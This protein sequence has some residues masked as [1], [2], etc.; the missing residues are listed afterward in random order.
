MSAPKH[1]DL[2]PFLSSVATPTRSLQSALPAIATTPAPSPWSPKTSSATAP[3][4]PAIDVEAI[5][6]E[7]IESGRAEGL[8]ETAALRDRL[9]MLLREL[10]AARAAIA[11][12]TTQMPTPRS[13]W[14]RRGSAARRAARCSPRS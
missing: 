2:Q 9:G 3:T 4:G 8:R 5:R 11:A 14:S 10:E 12:P 6:A 7:A 1:G 13:P